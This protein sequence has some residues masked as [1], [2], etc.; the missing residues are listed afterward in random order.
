MEHELSA[1]YDVTHGVGLAILTPN[2]MRYVL[3]ET[4]QGRF[5]RYGAAVWGLDPALPARKAA[6]AA[7]QKTRDF[8]SAS[9]GLPATLSELGIGPEYFPEMARKARNSGFDRTFVPLSVE[10]IVNIYQMSL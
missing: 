4:T 2:W 8:F 6:E 9:L 7:I 1:F 10:D 3:S 5:A